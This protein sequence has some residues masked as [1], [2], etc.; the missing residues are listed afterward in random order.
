MIPGKHYSW[1]I[2]GKNWE[3]GAIFRDVTYLQG[4]KHFYTQLLVGDP[5]DGIK[6]CPGVGKVNAE[7]IL[8][9]CETEID[10][11]NAARDAYQLEEAMILNGQVLW[12]Q[13]KANELWMPPIDTRECESEGAESTEMD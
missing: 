12:I 4:I 1:P 10:M 2:K 3:R 7:R 6:G 13:R 8:R 9:D 11:C 5:S